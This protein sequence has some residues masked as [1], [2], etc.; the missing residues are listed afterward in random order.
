M[1]NTILGKVR[2]NDIEAYKDEWAARSREWCFEKARQEETCII[3]ENDR[4]GGGNTL[5]TISRTF[6][7]SSTTV[8]P[9]SSLPTCIA[10]MRAL[11]WL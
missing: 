11:A 7:S 4:D 9:M 5:R 6:L 8:R 10:F 3:R 2:F 1:K